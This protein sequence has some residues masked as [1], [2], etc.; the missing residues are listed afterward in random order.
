MLMPSARRGMLLVP[1]VPTT[2]FKS[3]HRILLQKRDGFRPRVF[4]CFRITAEL[5]ILHKTMRG[6]VVDVK[7]VTLSELL[8][9]IGRFFRAFLDSDVIGSSKRQHR[10]FDLRHGGLVR[11]RG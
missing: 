11:Y 2:T 5:L 6:V 3:S 1:K 7:L 9:G 8:H 10:R 4:N